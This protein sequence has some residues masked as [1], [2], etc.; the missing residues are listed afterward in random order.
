MEALPK[1]RNFSASP[2][3]AKRFNPKRIRLVSNQD[4]L[5]INQKYSF[6][7]LYSFKIYRQSEN[8]QQQEE[9]PEDQRPVTLAVMGQLRKQLTDYFGEG[10]Y[11]SGRVFWS[12]KN[13]DEKKAFEASIITNTP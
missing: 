13:K 7:Y 3:L 9:V 6:I 2:Q 4:S 5:T 1:D 8:E 10:S 12:L 11:F